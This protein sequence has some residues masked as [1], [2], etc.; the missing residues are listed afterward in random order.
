MS[1]SGH[2]VPE[3]IRGKIFEP[4]FTTKGPGKG[5]GLGLAVV[6]GVVKQCG[7]Y[8]DVFSTSGGTSFELRFP[9]ASGRPTAAAAETGSPGAAGL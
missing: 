2:G 9:V 5:T 4:F 6:H 8:I 3:E 1:D 7:G